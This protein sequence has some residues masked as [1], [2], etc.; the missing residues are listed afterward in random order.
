MTIQTFRLHIFNTY[1]FDRTGEACEFASS[2]K[3]HFSSLTLGFF[4]LKFEL[5]INLLGKISFLIVVVEPV[6]MEVYM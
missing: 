5:V 4:A 2:W 1:L 6:E 3:S